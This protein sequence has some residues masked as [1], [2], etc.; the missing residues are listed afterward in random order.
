MPKK[1]TTKLF[2][3]L[4]PTPSLSTQKLC[5]PFFKELKHHI[6]SFLRVEL[7]SYSADILRDH[8]IKLFSKNRN[9]DRKLSNLQAKKCIKN[10]HKINFGVG[11]NSKF[12]PSE[13]G[14]AIF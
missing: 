11:T 1:T 13:T 8:Q 9:L 10:H 2:L 6:F 7:N 4:E 12:G 5:V 14:R 3:A